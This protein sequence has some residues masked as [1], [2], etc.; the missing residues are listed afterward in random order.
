VW[1]EAKE[2]EMA[3]PSA[4]IEKNQLKVGSP[5]VA[6]FDYV[7][8]SHRRLLDVPIRQIWELRELLYFLVWRDLKT[9]YKQAVI[10]AGWA[11]IKPLMMMI[12]FVVVF[13]LFVRIQTG[14]IPYSVFVYTGILPWT[15]VSTVIS[16]A[17][18]SLIT[19][20]S[21]LTKIYFPRLLIPLSASLTALVDLAIALLLLLG[22]MAWFRVSF[23]G[24][25][26]V[27]PILIIAMFLLSFG[28]GLV[29]A[30][31]HVKYHDVG[32]LLPIMLQMWMYA[33]PVIYPIDLVSDKWLPLYSL[34]PLV[35]LFQAFRWA[36]LDAQPPTSLM[37]VS[38]IAWTLVFF[39]SGLAYFRSSEDTFADIV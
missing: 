31:L 38:S 27:V 35:G 14:D 16:I 33:S 20:S 9:R 4:S 1:L 26:I 5:L 28:I 36:L 39:A 37:I 21:L 10:G 7:I 34:N 12:V 22:L 32:M 18:V 8:H 17:A 24:L 23:S 6:D 3:G 2:E 19:N 30:A 25:V 11:I 13:G 15:F 29:M